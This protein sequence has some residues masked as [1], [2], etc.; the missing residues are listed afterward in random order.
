MTKSL[1]TYRKRVP[2]EVRFLIAI[3]MA[4]VAALIY[5]TLMA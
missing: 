2:Y 1:K 3:S 4:W 5:A